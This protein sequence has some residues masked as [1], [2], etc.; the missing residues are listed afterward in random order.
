MIGAMFAIVSLLGVFAV[1]AG[2][3][4][5]RAMGIRDRHHNIDVLARR[6]QLDDATATRLYETA[7]RDG[8]GSAWVSIVENP[9]TD[10]SPKRPAPRSRRREIADRHQA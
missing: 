1:A 5:R 7:R 2:A 6:H 8:F 3:L 9:T 4:L 10:A